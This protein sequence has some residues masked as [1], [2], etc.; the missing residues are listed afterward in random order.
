MH[1][2]SSRIHKEMRSVTTGIWVTPA[3]GE[4][5]IA[6]LIKS[7]TAGIKALIS[8]C[9]LSLAFGEKNNIFCL[10]ARICDIPKNPLFICNVVRKKE[11]HGAL[12]KLLELQNFPI[13]LFNELDICFAW[14]DVTINKD[15]ASLVQEFSYWK[16]LYDGP[17]NATTSHQLDCLFEST[18]NSLNGDSFDRMDFI[19]IST[20][21]HKWIMNNIYIHGNSESQLLDLSDQ[22]EGATLEK[23]VWSSLESVFPFNIHM[24]PQVK[25]GEKNRELTDVLAIDNGITC[26]IEAKD[27]SLLNA[28]LSRSQ[29]RRANSSMRQVKKAIKQLVGASNAIKKKARPVTDTQ[30]KQIEINLEYPFHCIVLITE[31]IHDGDWGEVEKQLK[32]AIVDTENFFHILDLEELIVIL[33]HCKGSSDD[34]DHQLMGRGME[35]LESGSIHLRLN[36]I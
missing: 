19:E 29:L 5:D 4:G 21:P 25:S 18:D 3:I 12:K 28:D 10:G 33:K 7:S 24:S 27:L 8:G 13:F 1:I 2:P 30:G 11:D 6:L 15:D 20:S 14:S 22:N 32:N 36:P 35:F 17:L 31:M 26:L 9:D 23:L 16:A 34:F